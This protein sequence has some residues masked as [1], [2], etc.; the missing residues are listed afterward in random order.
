MTEAEPDMKQMLVEL[1]ADPDIPLES[2]EVE[3][4]VKDPDFHTKLAAAEAD[5]EAELEA[6]EA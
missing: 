4:M 1:A 2:D 5:I 3:E 6:L